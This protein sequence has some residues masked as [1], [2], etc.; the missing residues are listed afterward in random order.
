MASGLLAGWARPEVWVSN[1]QRYNASMEC[2]MVAEVKLV[3]GV[4]R[5]CSEERGYG[6]GWGVGFCDISL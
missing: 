4:R 6:T 1:L 2:F 3:V 5:K